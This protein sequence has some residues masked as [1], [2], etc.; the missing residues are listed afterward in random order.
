MKKVVDF[1][2]RAS[3]SSGSGVASAAI[4]QRGTSG[5]SHPAGIP[6]STMKQ[7]MKPSYPDWTSPGSIR[8]QLRRTEN[9]RAALAGIA[10]SLPI[11][12]TIF[13]PIHVQAN[14][15]R[16]GNLHLQPLRQANRRPRMDKRHYTYLRTG[17]LPKIP[18]ST[19][20][21]VQAARFTLIGG[22]LYKRSFTGPYLR[23]LSHSEALYV[24]AECTREYVAIILEDGL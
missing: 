2:G 20:I 10:A 4:P 22:H 1:T 11:K 13:L 18:G 17:T 16:R 5:A 6:A 12:E 15:F 21:R 8:L 14:S 7:N 19:K 3:R 24:L 23:C 9:G